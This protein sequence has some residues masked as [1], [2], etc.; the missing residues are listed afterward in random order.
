MRNKADS[1]KVSFSA[2]EAQ[3]AAS[4]NKA[5][6]GK[7]PAL[8][9]V[10]NKLEDANDQQ[11]A[12]AA[13]KTTDVKPITSVVKTTAPPKTIYDLF[14]QDK[15][16]NAAKNV[17]KVDAETKRIRFEVY[18]ATYFNYAKG[19]NNQVNAGAG[20]SSDIKLTKNLKLVTGV[21]IGQNTLSY[22]SNP[23]AAI[24][25]QSDIVAAA[26]V[27]AVAKGLSSNIAAPT[28]KITTPA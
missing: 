13:A 22:N 1:A 10:K 21:N 18:A 25:E 23:P 19:S 15:K 5:A 3:Q 26:F 8:D 4:K 9:S 11:L 12:L 7:A 2:I 14:A 24:A 20:F 28:L 6:N 16:V 27:P 17:E